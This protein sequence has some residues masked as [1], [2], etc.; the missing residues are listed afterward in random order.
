MMAPVEEAS[1]LR[2]ERIG[3]F[4]LRADEW[5]QTKTCEIAH[6]QWGA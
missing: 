1:L 2:P 4:A 5:R 6:T 3:G